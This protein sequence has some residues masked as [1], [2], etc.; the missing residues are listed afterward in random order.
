MLVESPKDDKFSHVRNEKLRQ[1]NKKKYKFPKGTCQSARR[2][3]RTH[4]LLDIYS[5][6][7]N[8]NTQKYD[9]LSTKAYTPENSRCIHTNL[10]VRQKRPKSL[11]YDRKMNHLF[12]VVRKSCY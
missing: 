10:L 3:F 4:Q 1:N 12:E 5:L 11:Q 2:K 7:S 6:I 8:C 9:M